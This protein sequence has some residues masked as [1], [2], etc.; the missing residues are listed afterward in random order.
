MEKKQME[1]ESLSKKY[2]VSKLGEKDIPA[3]L[4]VCE[5][6][7]QYYAYCPPAVSAESIR[8]DMRALPPGKELQDKYYLGFWDGEILI[9]VLD[10]ILEYP[11][12]DTAFIGFFMMNQ[13]MQGKGVGS[14]IVEEICTHLKEQF[15][16]VRLGY[17]KGNP[18]SEH[19]WKKNGFLPTG[20]ISKTEA[21]DVVVM[22]KRI[23]K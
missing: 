2:R 5:G 8:Q 4:K 20:V 3:I 15:L 17:V 19:F 7:P 23:A 21:Y 14:D 18:Q 11:N 10:L 16:A 12:K 6:N 9:A 1:I 22:E 13:D